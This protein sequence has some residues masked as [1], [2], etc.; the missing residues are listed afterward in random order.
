MAQERLEIVVSERGAP[1]VARSI[2]KIGDSSEKA[3]IQTNR[4]KNALFG[5]GA[6]TGVTLLKSLVDQYTSMSNRIKTVTSSAG[7]FRAVQQQLFDIAVK[8]RTPVE[9]VVGLYQRT[10]K[11]LQ[12][13]GRSGAESLRITELLNKATV[14]SGASTSEAAGALIQFAQGLGANR[15]SGQELNSI[16]EQMPIVADA[17]AAKLGVTRGELKKLGEQ[18]K[19]TAKVVADA[20]LEMGKNWDETFAKLKPT[21]AGSLEVVKTQFLK[22]L[23]EMDDAIGASE[24]VAKA[25][26]YL[27]QNMKVVVGAVATLATA[28]S[29]TLVQYALNIAIGRVLDFLKVL[30]VGPIISFATAI[31]TMSTA[32]LANALAF[33]TATKA[34]VLYMATLTASIF[35]GAGRVVASLLSIGTAARG[36]GGA[37]GIMGLALKGVGSAVPFILGLLNPFRLISVAATGLTALLAGGLRLAIGTITTALT[38]LVSVVGGFLSVAF[39]LVKIIALIGVGMVTLGDQTKVSEGSIVT[40]KDVALA[41]W[42]RIKVGMSTL[43]DYMGKAWAYIKGDADNAF[44]GSGKSFFDYARDIA[45]GMENIVAGFLAA[46]DTILATWKSLPAALADLIIQGVKKLWDIISTW[47]VETAKYLKDF[48]LKVISLDFDNI[49]SGG[50]DLQVEGA[51]KRVY[52]TWEDFYKQ[53]QGG[54]N[55]FTEEV[56][57]LEKESTRIATE[58]SAKRLKLAAEDEKARAD[59]LKQGTDITKAPGEDEKT[60]KKGFQDYLTELQREQQLMLLTGDAYKIANEQIEMANKLRRELTDSEKAQVAEVVAGNL[61]RERQRDLLTEINGPTEE[62]NMKL[63]ALNAL[64][65]SGAIDLTAYND[66]FFKLRENFLN[67]LPEATTFA[68]GF[69]IQIQKMQLATRNGFGQMGTEVAK[70]F[71]PGG[72]L[73]NGIGDAVAQSIVFGKS[74][75]EQI[76]G[77]AQSIL[78][79][80][81]GSLVKMG[82]NMVMNAGL[83]AALGAASTAQGTAQAGV[84]TAAYTPAAAMASLA[85]GGTNAAAAGAGISSVFSILTSLIGSIGGGLFK[86]GGYTGAV[87]QNDVAGLVHG[88][89]FVVNAQATKRHRSLLE[90]VNAGKDPMRPIAAAAAP[91]QVAVSITN[92]IPDAAYEVRPLGESEIEII[93]KRVVRREAPDIISNDLRNPNSRTS[94]GISNNTNAGRRR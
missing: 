21:I 39:G 87:G 88:Q 63:Q 36:V 32:I 30:I 74:F 50:L 83:N 20:V 81:I 73:I 33:G 16:L 94:K 53:R 80:L 31:G 78:S 27:G 62:Y 10:A 65:Q 60:K 56:N 66:Q 49:G 64:Y 68:D 11:T 91:A 4:L 71:G 35:T 3:A 54:L 59:M 61:A 7:Q 76:R 75:K 52:G 58:E 46:Y 93:A 6:A 5:L 18:G 90:A 79:Q 70:I 55:F 69:T 86:E 8:T 82:L 28:L 14:I 42:E 48:F 12:D 2:D 41:A 1:S 89:E 34:G 85:T 92:E 38:S 24:A 15:I 17:I 77:I 29:I 67:G 23:G 26:L 22:V 19:I 57:K 25:F 84:L 9:A 40:Y 37:V 44:K 43:V 45:K 47:A 72:T 13:M 51:A